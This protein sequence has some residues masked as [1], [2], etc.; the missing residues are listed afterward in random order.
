MLLMA[1]Q[2]V[3]ATGDDQNAIRMGFKRQVERN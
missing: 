3:P 2:L 1:C